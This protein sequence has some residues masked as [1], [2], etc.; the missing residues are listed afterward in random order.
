MR[1]SWKLWAKKTTP[2]GLNAAEDTS[3]AMDSGVIHHIY[4]KAWTP[5]H[6]VKDLP[7][8]AKGQIKYICFFN[9]V[10]EQVLK[11]LSNRLKLHAYYLFLYMILK[12]TCTIAQNDFGFVLFSPYE[13]IG[14]RGTKWT[15]SELNQSN[16]GRWNTSRL[17]WEHTVLKSK[18][19]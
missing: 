18:P 6:V 19:L 3:F 10:W 11:Y 9:L 12:E 1:I 15:N 8:C 4:R 16:Y 5:I 14:W 7:V 17:D 13:L 2:S